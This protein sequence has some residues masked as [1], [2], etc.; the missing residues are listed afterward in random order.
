MFSW[1]Q[2]IAL[3]VNSAPVFVISFSFC[4]IVLLARFCGFL[5]VFQGLRLDGLEPE[6]HLRGVVQRQREYMPALEH[7]PCNGFSHVHIIAWL[8]AFRK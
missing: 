1:L 2:N 4:L 5:G 8:P 3:S 7:L 6:T